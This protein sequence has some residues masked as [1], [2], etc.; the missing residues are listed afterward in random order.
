MIFYTKSMAWDR[1]QPVVEQWAKDAGFTKTE[2][3]KTLAIYR[4]P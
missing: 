1:A 3:F 2:E 4:K